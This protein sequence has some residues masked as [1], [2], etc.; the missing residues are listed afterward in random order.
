LLSST[1]PSSRSDRAAFTLESPDVKSGSD[2]DRLCCTV[3]RMGMR[4]E[5][6]PF[7]CISEVAADAGVTSLTHIRPSA[8]MVMTS[9][10]FR[11]RVC[12]RQK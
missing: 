5:F 3:Q 7:E 8:C 10:A 11:A 2:S 4:L 12:L 9:I 6:G 1:L